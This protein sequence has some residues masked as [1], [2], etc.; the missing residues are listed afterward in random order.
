MPGSSLAR[1]PSFTLLF[2]KPSSS[3]TVPIRPP[4]PQ[5]L[6]KKEHEAALVLFGAPDTCNSVHDEYAAEGDEGQYLGIVE[7]HGCAVVCAGGDAGSVM[8]SRQGFL[9]RWRARGSQ[10]QGGR[11]HAC[12]Q[13]GGLRQGVLALLA[14]KV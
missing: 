9:R 2:A 6:H 5:I 11:M 14:G 4:C 1:S 12:G 7:Q 10:G 13:L 8:F 3:A